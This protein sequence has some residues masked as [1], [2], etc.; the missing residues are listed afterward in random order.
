MRPSVEVLEFE[1]HRYKNL[2]EVRVE[3][4]R[5]VVL[6]GQNGSGK[7]NFLE[8][9]AL[10]FGSKASLW[11]L[12]R[13]AAVPLHAEISVVV[14]GDA[15]ELPLPPSF[16]SGGTPESFRRATAFWNML[17][18]EAGTSWREAVSGIEPAALA[19]LFRSFADRP[20]VRYRLS[21]LEGVEEARGLSRGW[22]DDDLWQA[23]SE[24]EFRR[25]YSRTL[26]LEGPPPGWLVDL[27]PDLPD[28]FAPLRRWLEE[29]EPRRGRYVDLLSLPPRDR[30]P[31]HVVWLASERTADE[32]VFDLVDVFED[33]VLPAVALAEAFEGVL[34]RDPP[35][36]S[37]ERPRLESDVRF[38]LLVRACRVATEALQLVAPHLE[39]YP[40]GEYPTG[41]MLDT[42]GSEPAPALR[43]TR[44]GDF[45]SLSSGQRTWLDIGLAQG[46]AELEQL[47][48]DMGWLASSLHRLTS[49]QQLAIGVQLEEQLSGEGGEASW[50]VADLDAALSQIRRSVGDAYDVLGGSSNAPPEKRDVLV[51]LLLEGLPDWRDVITPPAVLHFYDEP[52]RHLHPGA[53]RRIIDSFTHPRPHGVAIATHSHLFLGRSGWRHLHLSPTPEGAVVT[54]FEPA[55]IDIDSPLSAQLGLTHG[56]LLA[57]TRYV[58]FVEGPVDALVLGAFYR[59][60]LFEAGVVVVPMRGANEVVSLAQMELLELVLDVGMGVML[61]HADAGR[62]EAG[63]KPRT[64]EERALIDLRRRL[65]GRGRRMDLFGLRGEDILVYIE[66]EAVRAVYPEFSSWEG[67]RGARR[68]HETLK[69][70]TERMHEMRLGMHFAK[71]TV[72]AMKEL[73]LSPRGDL[74]TVVADIVRAANATVR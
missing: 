11:Q 62:L 21:E 18:V 66:D 10:A 49:D 72:A 41:L 36:T 67:L 16:V 27:A 33:A 24:V 30:A 3:W 50:L 23:A 4:D 34:L 44:R 17:G 7:T 71:R 29:S 43:L 46:A 61:D 40:D 38:W 65:R 51:Q 25:S 59:E 57:L 22:F 15:S 53:Q 28:A 58:L 13:R 1:V 73:G 54:A 9:I 35:D 20:L 64:K 60:L 8:A 63:G 37:E 32:A 2:Q 19:D 52:E 26:V 5:Q 74:P 68:G 45:E 39:L 55:A 14:R 42:R 70:V 6:Y 31:I 56:E 69:E 48:T 12:A 47:Q